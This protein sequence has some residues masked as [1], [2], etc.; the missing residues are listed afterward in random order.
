M[1]DGM[2]TSVQA[3]LAHTVMLLSRHFRTF[4]LK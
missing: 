3:D 1:R 2:A 4:G